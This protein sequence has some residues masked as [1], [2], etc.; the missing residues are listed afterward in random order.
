MHALDALDGLTG[1]R[2][3]QGLPIVPCRSGWLVKHESGVTLIEHAASISAKRRA[4]DLLCKNFNNHV[5]TDCSGIGSGIVAVLTEGL[6]RLNVPTHTW[7]SVVPLVDRSRWIHPAPL[8]G[9]R[10]RSSLRV[11]LIG[12][13]DLGLMVLH[14]LLRGKNLSVYIY[15]P[16]PIQTLDLYPFYCPEDIGLSKVDIISAAL[17]APV[18]GRIATTSTN[19]FSASGVVRSLT[20]MM[21]QV[22]VVICCLDRPNGI[23]RWL[24]PL[25]R[26]Q[27]L[28]LV[29]ANVADQGTIIGPV[30]AFPTSDLSAGCILCADLRRADRD[31]FHTALNEDLRARF[32]GSAP[33]RYHH[34]EATLTRLSQLVIMAL[35][36]A[37]LIR[38]GRCPPTMLAVAIDAGS[39]QVTWPVFARHHAC[40]LCI[41]RRGQGYLRGGGEPPRWWRKI[42]RAKPVQPVDPAVLWH[43]LQPWVG[44]GTGPFDGVQIVPSGERQAIWSFFETRGVRP[45][46]N[47]LA[48]AWRAVAI[49]PRVAK[50]KVDCTVTE[51]LDFSDKTKAAALAVLEGLER[52]FTLY[53]CDPRAIVRRRFRDVRSHALDPRSFPLFADH[54][55]LDPHF[56]LRRFDPD[57]VMRWLWGMNLSRNE[58][59]LVAFDL[60]FGSESPLKIYR[61]N[62]NGAAC[63]SSLHHA[64]LNG[65]YETI[66]RDALMVVWLDRLSLPRLEV[67]ATVPDRFALRATLQALGLELSYVDLTTDLGIPVL[68]GIIK[69][70]FNPNF[71]LLDMVSA[72]SVP[73]LLEKL[74]RELA[75]FIFPYLIHQQRYESSISTSFDCNR[76]ISFPDHLSFYQ[77]SAKHDQAAF[78][79]ASP[80]IRNI[81]VLPFAS[82][83]PDIIEEIDTLISRLSKYGYEVIVVNCTP[84]F[85]E[86]LGLYVIKVL[87]P[88]LQPLNAGHRLQVLG[89][90]RIYELPQRLGLANRPLTVADLNPW[91]HPFW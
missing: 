83:E 33:W 9:I 15:D 74:H 32:P 5:V 38:E 16:V 50:A 21:G 88:G 62:S 66:E 84:A 85:L 14:Q 71:F 13:G 76:V 69:D 56:P 25:C 43:R 45:K 19:D 8:I 65:I 23:A 26:R 77:W 51:A 59:V 36:K 78:L 28:P 47:A 40:P 86:R 30:S 29:M 3:W 6:A 18:R 39:C 49:Q 53:Y 17:P 37:L 34:P 41:P 91:P 60:I 80:D 52:L 2:R 81:G 67:G 57:A 75:Q 1:S 87:I 11:L 54:Q 7:P 48:N 55:Y 44:H 20:S 82:A 31:P 64:I 22:D 35:Y 10:S 12:L 4:V 42:Y 58:P 63:H 90:T 68:L 24:A 70:R 61:A 79:T 46:D 89:G 27:R 73:R 72:W